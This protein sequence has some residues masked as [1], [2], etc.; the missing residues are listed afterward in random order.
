MEFF[1]WINVVQIFTEYFT[2]ATVSSAAEYVQV[3]LRILYI[4]VGVAG[5]LYLICLI[6]GGLGMHTMAKKVGMKHSW[7]A[8]L[9]LANTW[10]AGKLAGETRLFGQKM[11]R[12]GLYATLA[13]IVYIGINVF[14]LVVQFALYRPEYF[15][16][17]FNEAGEFNGIYLEVA[18]IPLSLRW[19]VVANSVLSWGERHCLSCAYPLLLCGFLCVLPQILCAQS[20]PHDLPVC[21]SSAARHRHFCGA[22]QHARRL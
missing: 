6:L 5:G 7:L 3:V 17:R 2:V 16:E 14:A 4:S 11:K 10:Y 19:L 12:A 15:V 22:Q 8:F 13:E 18:R 1:D 21:G 9:P 20:L